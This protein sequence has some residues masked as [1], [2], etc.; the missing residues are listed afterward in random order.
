MKRTVLAV[1]VAGMAA[2]TMGCA[3]IFAGGN[4]KDVHMDAEPR[5]AEVYVDGALRGQTPVVLELDRRKSHTVVFK[6][7]GY[8]DATC[9]LN[10]SA[11]AGWIV[12]DILLTGLIGVIVDAATGAWN[13]IGDA[14][15]SVRLTADR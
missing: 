11:G 8:Q 6:L 1:L 10:A 15:C 2:S 5:G 14:M 13:S 3:A 12:L 7:D 4:Q 9:Q